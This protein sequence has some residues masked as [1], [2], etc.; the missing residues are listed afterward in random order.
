[1][2][3][4]ELIVNRQIP[5]ISYLTKERPEV[6]H[7]R[8]TYIGDVPYVYC[9]KVAIT[10]ETFLRRYAD[11]EQG[12]W[13]AGYR[14]SDSRQTTITFSQ[15][16]RLTLGVNFLKFIEAIRT[17]STNENYKATIT[18]EGFG[19][20]TLGGKLRLSK[21][22]EKEN[23]LLT[24]FEDLKN[25]SDEVSFEYAN[26]PGEDVDAIVKRRIG[27]GPFRTLLQKQYQVS[28]WLSGLAHSQLLIASH[29]VPWSKSTPSQQTDHENGLLLSVSWDAL[30]DKGLISFDDGGELL[31]SE[32]LDEDTVNCLGISMDVAL[33][34][35]LMTA[36]RKENLSW[37]RE[38]YGFAV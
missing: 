24:L 18:T 1:M 17:E 8:I 31:R 21:K 4:Q 10:L 38:K 25:A 28:C 35:K 5:E 27:Q 19:N 36:R 33:P 32:R 2:N 30:F 29:I 15:K 6:V 22:A 37:H 7:P 14:Q 23:P 26:K 20:D 11:G 3:Y 13:L 9:Q 12:L 16:N 34:F